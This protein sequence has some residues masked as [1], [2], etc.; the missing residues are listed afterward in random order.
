MI[1]S[2]LRKKS[3]LLCRIFAKIL[4][5][6]LFASAFTWLIVSENN[7]RSETLR[8]K[9]VEQCISEFNQE[10]K[11]NEDRKPEKV[12][13]P[14]LAGMSFVFLLLIGAYE[15]LSLVLVRL[16]HGVLLKK[17][18]APE[19]NNT[20]CQCRDETQEESGGERKIFKK[21]PPPGVG[22][23]FIVIGAL[24]VLWGYFCWWDS[25]FLEGT[26]DRS[27][28]RL[29]GGVFEIIFGLML[30]SIGCFYLVIFSPSLLN[31]DEHK[32]Q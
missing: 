8:T 31:P 9:T 23:A 13:L 28:Y 16:I 20:D 24:T 22:I 6:V 19:H 27:G 26:C 11:F 18:L 10:K 32:E 12:S 17:Y 21:V 4:L 30:V 29:S 14:V 1:K 3:R 2:W 25:G 5:V 15:F 7:Q